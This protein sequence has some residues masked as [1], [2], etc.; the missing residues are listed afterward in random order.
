[1]YQAPLYIKNAFIFVFFK[2]SSRSISIVL[3]YLCLTVMCVCVC[4]CVNT[5]WSLFW[6]LLK[7]ILFFLTPPIW[8]RLWISR[9]LTLSVLCI[10]RF[11]VS[12]LHRYISRFISLSNCSFLFLFFFPFFKK[13]YL[14]TIYKTQENVYRRF[15]L[16]DYSR[17]V[18][19]FFFFFFFFFLIFLFKCFSLLFLLSFPV[20]LTSRLQNI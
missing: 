16:A 4:V 18:F 1:M 12:I 3:V 8:L 9:K 15:E 5:S 11:I 20:I 2:I 10:D 19:F 7:N 17:Y 14:T 6:S 13:K